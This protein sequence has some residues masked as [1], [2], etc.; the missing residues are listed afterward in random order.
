MSLMIVFTWTNSA[1]P[2][3]VAPITPIMYVRNKNSNIQGRP[4]NVI[5]VIVYTL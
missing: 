5:K 3:G 4:L 2:I 1:E